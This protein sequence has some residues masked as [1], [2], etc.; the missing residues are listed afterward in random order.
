MKTSCA[1]K[2]ILIFAAMG[3]AV[4]VSFAQRTVVHGTV[5]DSLSQDA[6]EEATIAVF[7]LP[8]FHLL[9]QVRSARSGFS[10]GKI[11][12]GNYV[13]VASFQGYQPDSIR[14]IIKEKDSLERNLS[15]T[16]R[17]GSE[18]LMEVVVHASI[19]PVIVRSD[20][21]A[22]NAQAYPSAPNATL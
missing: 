1:V 4:N 21:I 22:F 6:M 2:F 5:V 19:P 12:H 8:D 18:N 15:F 9:R 14:F 7:A 17:P 10:L 11:G 3:M 13:A 16:L 20:T